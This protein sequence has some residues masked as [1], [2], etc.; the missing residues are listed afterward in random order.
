MWEFLDKIIYI[1]LDHRLDRMDVINKFIKEGKF[2][3]EKVMRF[4]AIKESVGAVGCS[5]SHI[6]V[7]EMAIKQNYGNILILEDDVEWLCDVNSC[8]DQI[9]NLVSSENDVV[10]L[11]GGYNCIVDTNQALFSF[12]TSSYIVKKHYFERL[13]S[14]FK[15][16][17]RNLIG[18]DE[19][20]I[21]PQ[22]EQRIKNDHT[23][24]L[25]T[26]WSLLMRMD[27][28][29]VVIPKCVNQ[30]ASYSDVIEGIRDWQI[31]E[32]ANNPFKR[33]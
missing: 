9:K 18:N 25:D 21:Y 26:C 17:L 31:K 3:E 2:P 14:N 27:N 28:W 11:G 6:A 1:N 29:R 19:L 23:N 30:I 12:C 16:S 7:I 22:D 32:Q 8:Y 10:L 15:G 4:S 20:K 13:L 24:E 5:K 33:I